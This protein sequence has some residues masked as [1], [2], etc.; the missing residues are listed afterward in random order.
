[1]LASIITTYQDFDYQ[2]RFDNLT[3]LLAD[4]QLCC[5]WKPIACSINLEN[6]ADGRSLNY[7]IKVYNTGKNIPHRESSM[8]ATRNALFA[9]ASAPIMRKAIPRV[10]A[11]RAI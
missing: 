10:H 3:T 11:P 2:T 6:L 9:E 7:M 4:K 1:M 8:I 5:E